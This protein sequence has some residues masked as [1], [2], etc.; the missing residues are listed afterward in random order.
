MRVRAAVLALLLAGCAG[1]ASA[2]KAEVAPDAP[3]PE[4]QRCYE[5]AE[6]PRIAQ[7][8]GEAD[9]TVAAF[10]SFEEEHAGCEPLLVP[11]DKPQAEAAVLRAGLGL[12][13]LQMYRLASQ[14]YFSEQQMEQ[15]CSTLQ[16]GLLIGEQ[17][18]PLFE[19][20]R[21]VD[22]ATLPESMRGLG[23]KVAQEAN[24]TAGFFVFAQ[25]THCAS[26]GSGE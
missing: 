14:A 11:A 15:T 3:S 26:S 20:A 17:L 25:G 24:R 12:Q 9:A 18:R 19:A 5:V 21:K 13:R 22:E 8:W 4:L 6:L 2:T 10:L 1:G 16:R 23:E 7:A